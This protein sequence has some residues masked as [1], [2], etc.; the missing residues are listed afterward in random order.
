MKA[1]I[2]IC[3]LSMILYKLKFTRY[4]LQAATI[5]ELNPEPV[6]INR[7]R[8]KQIRKQESPA[9]VVIVYESRTQLESRAANILTAHGVKFDVWGKVRTLTNNELNEIITSGIL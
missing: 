3:F 5:E 4:L 2:I 1:I 8:K 6:T 7:K 9:P